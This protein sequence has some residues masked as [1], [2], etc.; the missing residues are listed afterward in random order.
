MNQTTSL[1]RY[2]Y[3]VEMHCFSEIICT[4]AAIMQITKKLT[5]AILMLIAAGLLALC[6]ASIVSAQ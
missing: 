3:F 5:N 1:Q 6:V 2:K 4:F